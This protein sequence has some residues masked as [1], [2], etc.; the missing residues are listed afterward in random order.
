MCGILLVQSKHTIDI[1]QHLSALKILESRGPDYTRYQYRNNIFIA[2]A[3]LHITGT[4]DF[5]N[6]SKT[7]FLAY[8]GEIYNKRWFGYTDS[9]DVEL[10][11]SA[12]KDSLKK[13]K[14]FEGPWAWAYTD[15]EKVSYASDPQGE[16]YLYRYQDN[17]ILIVCSEVA[18]ILTYI[19]AVK[20]DV[21]Y[22]NKTWTMQTETPW[23][24]IQRLEPGQLYS[25]QES[26][27]S[28]D[29]VWSWIKPTVYTSIEEAQE[30]FNRLWDKTMSE[31]RP[32]TSMA[33]SYSGGIDSS[34]ILKAFPE[35][36]L[37]TIDMKGKD[38]IAAG[39]AT[40]IQVDEQQYAQE[41]L[42]LLERTKMPAQS[43]SFVGKW[44][45]AKA[46]DA[47]VLFTG[48]GAD[49]LFGGY[50]VYQ[51]MKYDQ[52]KSHSPYSE[53]GDPVI[54]QRCLDAYSGDARQ[55]TLLMDYWYQVIGCDAPGL[56]RIGGAWGIETRNPFLSRRIIEFALNLPWE[57]KVNTVTKPI[58]RKRFEQD[59]PDH[60]I[61][62]KQGFAGHANDALPW[63]GVEI[64]PTGNRYDDWK[65]IART[66]F[67]ANNENPSS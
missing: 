17:D 54:W 36:D 27:Y 65:Q 34:L 11:Y 3:V 31:I 2:Q 56:D 47:R 23:Q 60:P 35:I 18:P 63:L 49:E 16:H 25:G 57:Y 26:V 32:N 4:D 22:S 20:V 7:D 19:D 21:P 9:N 14:H 52:Q 59:W 8:N 33:L 45:V 1:N 30:E 10:V 51:T 37:I 29:N 64:T 43:W 58:L 55:A 50:S 5:Y 48:L 67:Y 40:A 62:P 13:F 15:F 38:P 61:L 24:G 6:R 66:T 28:I 12:V 41:Y 44:M 53:H 42:E 46:C 39:I